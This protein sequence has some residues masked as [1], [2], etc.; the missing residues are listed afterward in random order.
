[1]SFYYLVSTDTAVCVFDE[2]LVSAF[3][4]P[5][6]VREP[7]DLMQNFEP[8]DDV[9]TVASVVTQMRNQSWKRELILH[10][11]L[12]TGMA[13]SKTGLYSKYHD[14]SVYELGYNH[15]TTIRNAFM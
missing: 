11:H 2:A 4:Q 5:D 8:L 15:P 9:P 14:N 10:D 7:P 13:E 1:M 6:T 12:L 3:Q